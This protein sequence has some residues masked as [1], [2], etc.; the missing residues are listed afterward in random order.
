M[1]NEW[2]QQQEE[3]K[4][5]KAHHKFIFVSKSLNK[6]PDSLKGSVHPDNKYLSMHAASF[7]FLRFLPVLYF[8]VCNFLL[9]CLPTF[10]CLSCATKLKW[11]NVCLRVGVRPSRLLLSGI[12][13]ISSTWLLR[14]LLETLHIKK[15]KADDIQ[16]KCPVCF[17][18]NWFY[19][20]LFPPQ[21]NH[22]R[23]LEWISYFITAPTTNSH[24]ISVWN[25]WKPDCGQTFSD[26]Q[27]RYTVWLKPGGWKWTANLLLTP[28]T[29]WINPAAGCFYATGT[30]NT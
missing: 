5:C 16:E 19:S 14:W 30:N 4:L 24:C 22:T 1:F 2:I 26:W 20:R 7:G 6:S 18:P 27:L 12:M 15:L 17:R 10:S 25:G 8:S 23:R 21:W 29:G 9:R 28:M 3:V 13:N 11:F